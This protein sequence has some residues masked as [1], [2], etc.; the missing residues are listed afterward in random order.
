MPNKNTI[1][2]RRVFQENVAASWVEW[3]TAFNNYI[4]YLEAMRQDESL[5]N[6]EKAYETKRCGELLM[7]KQIEPKSISASFCIWKDEYSP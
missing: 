5:T 6:L 4:D 3:D 7:M 2:Y 1:D